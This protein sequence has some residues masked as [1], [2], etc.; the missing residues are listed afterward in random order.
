MHRD[1]A[2]DHL[3][4]VFPL[5]LVG[6]VITIRLDLRW[7]VFELDSHACALNGLDGDLFISGLIL[8]DDD[9][10][11]KSW[12]LLEDDVSRLGAPCQLFLRLVKHRGVLLLLCLESRIID[13]S[14][15]VKFLPSRDFSCLMVAFYCDF[16]EATACSCLVRRSS[17][18]HI[19]IIAVITFR[20]IHDADVAH[21]AVPLLVPARS[22]TIAILADLRAAVPICAKLELGEHVPRRG[23]LLP[24]GRATR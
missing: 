4:E 20:H 21:L 10:L 16:L 5:L 1:E 24:R 17:K 11:L 8:D 15:V 14:H 22:L 2:L 6:V 9:A 3:L 18:S 23:A 13:S 7:Q 19:I 12:L